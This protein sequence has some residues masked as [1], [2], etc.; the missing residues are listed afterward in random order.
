MF[1]PFFFFFGFLYFCNYN[2]FILGT[3]LEWLCE[4]WRDLFLGEI[5]II[6]IQ[7][8]E[9]RI[10]FKKRVRHTWKEN[11]LASV[12]LVNKHTIIRVYYIRRGRWLKIFF[13]CEFKVFRM[14]CSYRI[15]TFSWEFWVTLMNKI[16]SYLLK[17]PTHENQMQPTQKYSI[18]QFIKFHNH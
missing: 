17:F 8:E 15:S 18:I 2:E 14:W 16:Y 6:L 13:V 11:T 12:Y 4:F 1:K 5:K 9:Y 3:R 10:R 7:V